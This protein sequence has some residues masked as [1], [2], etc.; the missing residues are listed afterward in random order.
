MEEYL[1]DG[2]YIFFD[3]FGFWL[4]ANGPENNND[5]IYLEPEVLKA[6]NEFVERSTENNK[7]KAFFLGEKE[8]TV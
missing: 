4:K 3:G 5:R 2:V 6:L 7:I 1:G 8:P